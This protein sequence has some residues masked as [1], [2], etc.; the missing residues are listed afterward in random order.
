MLSFGM[1]VTESDAMFAIGYEYWRDGLGEL[2]TDIKYSLFEAISVTF[3]EGYVKRISTMQN[4]Q[5]MYPLLSK[6]ASFA[7]RT[8]HIYHCI[9]SFKTVIICFYQTSTDNN[10]LNLSNHLRN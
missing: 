9:I 8:N 7:L 1:T 10:A 4:G 3:K 5:T 6:F 2:P